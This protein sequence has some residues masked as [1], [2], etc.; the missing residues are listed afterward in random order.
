MFWQGQGAISCPSGVG[1]DLQL[2][3]AASQGVQRSAA[4]QA[5][6]CCLYSHGSASKINGAVAFGD[7]IELKLA[8]HNGILINWY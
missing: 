4:L 6:Y 1:V 2:T 7:V 8:I 5:A 3:G